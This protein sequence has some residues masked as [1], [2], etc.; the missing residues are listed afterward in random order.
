MCDE[1]ADLFQSI[2]GVV[3]LH[4]YTYNK[5]WL[6]KQPYILLGTPHS[7][8]LA[9]SSY[10]LKNMI[11]PLLIDLDQHW[12]PNGEETSEDL[13]Q[14]CIRTWPIPSKPGSLCLEAW[15][16]M[17]EDNSIEKVCKM[18]E[19]GGEHKIVTWCPTEGRLVPFALHGEKATSNERHYT[20][21]ISPPCSMPTF[22]TTP[23][24]VFP[25]AL[26]EASRLN[27]KGMYTG[28]HNMGCILIRI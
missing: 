9:S 13:V 1:Y 2:L 8:N 7:L 23:R 22:E 6:M 26:R 11:L 4:S 10:T 25:G 5:G 20:V 27:T 18:N 3:S 16:E 14:A 28:N 17:L 15:M 24:A 19:A 12:Y 21:H